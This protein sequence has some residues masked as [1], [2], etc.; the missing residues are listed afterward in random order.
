MVSLVKQNSGG[1]F[2]FDL[3]PAC[4]RMIDVVAGI[5]DGQLAGGTPCDDFTVAGLLAHVD[6]AAVR[7]AAVTRGEAAEPQGVS[8]RELIGHHVRALATAWQEPSAWQGSTDLGL[9]LANEV[10]GRIALTE[11]VVHGWDLATATGQPFDVPE[12]TLRGCLEYLTEF[13]PKLPAPARSPW[14]TAVPVSPDAPLLDRVIGMAG[15]KP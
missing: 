7:L 11:M 4:Q 12:P 13:L 5:T 10:W 14:G 8:P 2:V 3:R 6:A 1:K 9:E 15:R